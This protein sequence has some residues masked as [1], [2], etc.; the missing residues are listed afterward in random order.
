LKRRQTTWRA[1]VVLPNRMGDM[2]KY[3]DRRLALREEI[4]PDESAYDPPEK[5]WFKA[6]RALPLFLALMASK[7][8]SGELD[9]TRVYL[10]LLARHIDGGFVELGAEADH[11]MAAGYSG[12]RAIRTWRE[13]IKILERSGFVK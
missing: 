2:T 5:G 13:R 9:P 3:S 11:A 10:E 12:D 7:R 4:F 1:R 8:V 6:S